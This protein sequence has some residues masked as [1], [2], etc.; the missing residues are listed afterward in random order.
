LDELNDAGATILSEF[1]ERANLSEILTDETR[2]LTLFAPTNKAFE[3]LEPTG[4]E[5]FDKSLPSR[6]SI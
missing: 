4:E 2:T 6:I 5:N 1:F 3:E